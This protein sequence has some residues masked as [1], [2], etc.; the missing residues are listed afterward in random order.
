LCCKGNSKKKQ[1]ER[2]REKDGDGLSLE[3]QDFRN[4]EAL[5]KS[6]VGN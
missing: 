5:V 3:E 4:T 1:E 2:R 6:I